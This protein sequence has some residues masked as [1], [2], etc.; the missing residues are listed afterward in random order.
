MEYE[1]EESMGYIIP[2]QALLQV[3]QTLLKAGVQTV[4][5]GVMSGFGGADALNETATKIAGDT[6]KSITDVLASMDP[7]EK[8]GLG[9]LMGLAGENGIAKGLFS[10]AN[11]GMSN[12]LNGLIQGTEITLDDDGNFEG[13]RFNGRTFENMTVGE[14]ALGGYLSSFVG[15]ASTQ[16]FQDLLPKVDLGDFGIDLKMDTSK[17]NA[18]GSTLGGLMGEL[19]SVAADGEF[20][21]NLLNL[22]DLMIWFGGMGTKE[23]Q[24]YSMGLFEFGIGVNDQ[25]NLVSRSRFGTGGAKLNLA[26]NW[27]V[28]DQIG[29][30]LNV[31]RDVQEAE[32]VLEAIRDGGPN[33]FDGDSEVSIDLIEM[34]AA[35]E[36]RLRPM[37]SP[38]R[39]AAG[40]ENLDFELPLPKMP[41]ETAWER[42]ERERVEERQQ[43]EGEISEII[44]DFQNLDRESLRR[45]PDG[46]EVEEQTIEDTIARLREY[47]N[48]PSGDDDKGLVDLAEEF[49]RDKIDEDVQA[50]DFDKVARERLLQ[51]DATSLLAD[52]KQAV[53]DVNTLSS[54]YN[55]AQ[56]RAFTDIN[57]GKDGF[58]SD[59]EN[60]LYE[61]G[62]YNSL[63]SQLQEDGLVDT[64][65]L[66]NPFRPDIIETLQTAMN[67][68]NAALINDQNLI[69][70]RRSMIRVDG[71]I[72]FLYSDATQDPGN[73]DIYEVGTKVSGRYD[74]MPEAAFWTVPPGAGNDFATGWAQGFFQFIHNLENP[75]P[76]STYTSSRVMVAAENAT[77]GPITAEDVFA[78]GYMLRE[79]DHQRLIQRNALK[80]EDQYDRFTLPKY[81]DNGLLGGF[82]DF[83][84]WVHHSWKHAT[85]QGYRETYDQA[86]AEIEAIKNR[87]SY[88]NGQMVE[89]GRWQQFE[90]LNRNGIEVLDSA[91][92]CNV[93]TG[94]RVW[95]Y[96]NYPNGDPQR[97][98]EAQ[99]A[100]TA[101]LGS[102]TLSDSP[103]F[104]KVSFDTMLLWGKLNALAVGRMYGAAGA[105]GHLSSSYNVRIVT[106]PVTDKQR[107]E[108]Y[109][110]NIGAHNHEQ[111]PTSVAWWKHLDNEL[112]TLNAEYGYDYITNYITETD[113][114][115]FFVY[116]GGLQ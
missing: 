64:Y 50:F 108:T 72:K 74:S 63:I 73:A 56:V 61:Y 107:I 115:D 62:E 34:L 69:H 35:E 39:L 9:G 95:F 70:S 6:G 89:A 79:I 22:S 113:E 25:G 59:V 98:A 103:H 88:I 100:L 110:S 44:E 60:G 27:G 77:N 86:E 83:F 114:V 92:W 109:W 12:V 29:S 58:L 45:D 55:A 4:M 52:L 16:M 23:A 94:Q 65:V 116:Y 53:E 49:L 42:E 18:L 41:A 7:L 21:M 48:V 75:P 101:S 13:F 87:S 38:Q 96:E 33:T 43:L 20:T 54:L 1:R 76:V 57:E 30:V 68:A 85:D 36:D 26:S 46:Q 14:G 2:E 3:G 111:A 37:V 84:D 5:S 106:D 102:D 11:Q 17:I 51:E 82:G 78:V 112:N 90:D 81:Q 67:D 28:W 31:N 10:V 104:G 32:K 91:T 15:T 8:F 97:A 71:E 105:S 47:L 19:A 66:F 93:G 99:I 40:Q 80:D 24:N